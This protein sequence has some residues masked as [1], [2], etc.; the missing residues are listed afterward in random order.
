MYLPAFPTVERE[1]HALP[2]SIE[3]T[4]A[5]FFI[6]MALGQL[7]YGPL[8]DRFGRRRPLMAGLFLYSVASLACAYALNVH[9]LVVMRFLE[10]L[11]GCAGM[12]ITRAVIRDRCGARDAA[13]AFSML[14]LVMGLAPILAPLIGGVVLTWLGWREIFLLLSLYGA[15]ALLAVYH[16]LPE[17]HDITH[18]PP[19]SIGRVFGNYGRLLVSRSFIGYTLAGGFAFAGM[20]AYIAGSPF[21][22]IELS[23]IPAQHFGWVFGLNA[24]G[25]VLISQVNA[26]LLKKHNLTR[27]LHHALWL[28]AL[29]GVALAL[30]GMTDWLVLPLILTGFFVYVSSLG[31]IGPNAT[32]AALATHG[33]QAGSASAL[34]GALQF[35]IATVAG[36]MVGIWHDGTSRPLTLVMAFCGVGALL[37]H[38]WLAVPIRHEEHLAD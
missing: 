1:L 37:V 3:Y 36:S 31:F 29:S 18:E 26:Q 20:F 16:G 38:R 2:G 19:L 30:A 11:G 23:G 17:T 6:G 24:M 33:Q 28:P 9:M 5:S 25:F 27:M 12:V 21:V 4:L 22:L 32:A 15:M 35:G 13:R 14:I 8:S 34:M 7:F 10:A